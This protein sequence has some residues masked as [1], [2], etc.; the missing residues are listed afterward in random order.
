MGKTL[1]Q[2]RQDELDEEFEFDLRYIREVLRV[3]K[4]EMPDASPTSQLNAANA[5]MRRMAPAFGAND[6]KRSKR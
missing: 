4:E 6:Q 1:G 2:D 3:I 5:F